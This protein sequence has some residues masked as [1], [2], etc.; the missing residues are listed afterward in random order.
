MKG[1]KNL[2]RISY[3]R[4]YMW[5]AIDGT[6]I[7]LLKKA[8]QQNKPVDYDNQL[9]FYSILSQQVCHHKW[10]FLYV[11]I[12]A[13]RGSHDVAHLR[14]S[15][16]WQKL[17]NGELPSHKHQFKLLSKDIYSYQIGNSAY[18]SL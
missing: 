5:G 17:Q 2:T 6:H 11:C 10:K 16:L 12:R 8:K 1:F 18:P 13:P 9:D 15:T 14:R 4:S 3:T 7:R